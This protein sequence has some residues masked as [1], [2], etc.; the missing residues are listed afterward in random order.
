MNVDIKDLYSSFLPACLQSRG[1]PKGKAA[2]IILTK[3]QD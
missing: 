1:V 3:D 2:A